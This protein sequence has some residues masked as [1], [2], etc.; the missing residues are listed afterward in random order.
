MIRTI[1]FFCL[2]AVAACGATITAS[3]PSRTDVVAAI[4]ESSTGDTIQIPAG[5][6]TWSSGVTIPSGKVLVIQGAGSGSTVITV[7]ASVIGLSFPNASRITAIGF[8]LDAA[9]S[10]GVKITAGTNW[11]VDHCAFTSTGWRDAVYAASD[12][13]N[14]F[15]GLIDHITST[16]CRFLVAPE[17]LTTDQMHALWYAASVIG[18]ANQVYIEDCTVVLTV[19]GNVID[20]N[21][22]GAFVFRHNIVTDAYIEAHSFQAA[23][24]RGAKSWEIYNNTVIQSSAAMNF[25]LDIRSGTGVIFNNVVQ[26]TWSH[27][28]GFVNNVRSSEWRGVAAFADGGIDYDINSAMAGGTGT[29][30]GSS[31][32]AVL[33]DA[34]KSWTTNELVLA[35]ST[36]G[37]HTGSNNAAIL[38]DGNLVPATYFTTAGAGGV[39]VGYIVKNV[40]DGSYGRVTAVTDTTLTATL[41]GGLQNDWDTGDTYEI[42]HGNWVHNTT[43]G[44]RGV[45]V[46]NTATTITA[47]LAGGSDNDWDTGDSYKVTNG[48]PARDQI[49]RGPD[50]A[51]ASGETL[52]WPAQTFDPVYYWNNRAVSSGGSLLTLAVSGVGNASVHI[53]AGR[54]FYTDGTQRP[55][56]TAY[57]YPHPL[58]GA[59]NTLTITGNLNVGTL[60]IVAP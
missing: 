52:P 3:S 60:N 2:S 13:A 30:T 25:P 43:D 54:D 22:G 24:F 14:A 18:T 45:I 48:Y 26:G 49:G 27:P 58:Q 39:S 51:L 59:T 11:R 36:T 7:A 12:S 35:A 29:H 55:G 6:A 1:L 10:S 16:N 15:S 4:T 34:T 33:T 9:A 46:S 53:V 21:Y 57:T 50:L 47:I 38:T 41:I 31:N 23:G 20:C 37:T 8:N 5:S 42:I 44:S 17:A 28:G 19:F 56:Y 40:T 32:F